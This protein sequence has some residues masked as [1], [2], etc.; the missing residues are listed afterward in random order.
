MAGTDWNQDANILRLS[1]LKAGRTNQRKTTYA[2]WASF[3]IKITWVQLSSNYSFT[4]DK[5]TYNGR[6]AR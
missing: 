1:S 6:N 4:T 3:P 2:T 5:D